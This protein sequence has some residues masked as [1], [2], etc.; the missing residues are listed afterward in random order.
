MGRERV[1]ESV[2]PRTGEILV[3]PAV[4][5]TIETQA[6]FQGGRLRFPAGPLRWEAGVLSGQRKG[7]REGGRGGMGWG[8]KERLLYLELLHGSRVRGVSAHA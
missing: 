1:G 5:L 6:K 3:G 8:E 2:A 7:G 4:Q